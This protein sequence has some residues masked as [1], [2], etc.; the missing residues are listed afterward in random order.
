MYIGH[1]LRNQ[2]KYQEAVAAYEK[3]VTCTKKMHPHWVSDAH[4]YIGHVY[5]Y[6]LKDYP[7]AKA[8]FEQVVNDKKAHPSHVN[9]A[10]NQLKRI[11]QLT[12]K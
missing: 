7:K 4:R 5:L 11:E 3:A 6:N 2:K 9:D 8:A 1:S 12:K 10:K